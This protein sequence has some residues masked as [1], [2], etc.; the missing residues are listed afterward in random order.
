MASDFGR[1]AP[2]FC[3]VF[4]SSDDGTNLTILSLTRRSLPLAQF[5]GMTEA[6]HLGRPA[7]VRDTTI[8]QQTLPSMASAEAKS[9]PFIFEGAAAPSEG[10]SLG[11]AGVA[12]APAARASAEPSRQ[13]AAAGFRH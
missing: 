5:T 3:G 12:Q 8:K 11:G 9:Q 2:S 7:F 6:S 4:L 1:T 13:G 10:S